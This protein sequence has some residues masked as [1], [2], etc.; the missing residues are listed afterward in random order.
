[1]IV[2]SAASAPP[3]LAPFVQAGVCCFVS[4]QALDH[5]A[6]GRIRTFIYGPKNEGSIARAAWESLLLQP[7]LAGVGIDLKVILARIKDRF[8]AD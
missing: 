2:W 8:Q 5:Q 1:M 4:K 3:E 7:N 6:L